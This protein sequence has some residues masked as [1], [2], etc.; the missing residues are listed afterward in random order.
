MAPN[1]VQFYLVPRY[2]CV[3]AQKGKLNYN[4]IEQVFN[5]M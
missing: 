1:T 2:S 5:S 4:K 3:R